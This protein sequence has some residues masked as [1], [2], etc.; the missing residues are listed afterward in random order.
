LLRSNQVGVYGFALLRSKKLSVSLLLRLSLRRFKC[1]LSDLVSCR[2]RPAAQAA[3]ASNAKMLAQVISQRWTILG[4]NC[5]LA[6]PEEL[7]QV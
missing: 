2:E 7:G 1:R 6:P 4:G 3:A 5:A